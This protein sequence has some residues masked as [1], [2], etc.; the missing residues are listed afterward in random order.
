MNYTLPKRFE[1]TTR[2]CYLNEEEG[3]VGPFSAQEIVDLLDA[4]TI[5]PKTMVVEMGTGAMCRVLQ[6]RPFSDY[7]HHLVERKRADRRA[8][9]AFRQ[10]YRLVERYGLE[11]AVFLL[12]GMAFL[13]VIAAIALV[14]LSQSTETPTPLAKKGDKVHPTPSALDHTDAVTGH[15]DASE[16][17]NVQ[18]RL[19]PSG[20]VL[21]PM[22]SLNV[23][24]GKPVGPTNELELVPPGLRFDV[25]IDRNCSS[26]HY[27]PTG[28]MGDDTEL[29]VSL[30]S[31][32]THED[33]G[34][35]VRIEYGAQ[36]RAGWAG[37]YWQN[38]A[39]NWGTEDG[40]LNLT[41]FN[42][43]V[44]KARGSKGGE[45]ISE[46]KVGGIGIGSEVPHPDTADVSTK[47]IWLSD[48]WQLYEVNLAGEDLSYISGGF[49]VVFSAALNPDGAVIFVD[50]VYFTRDESLKP[51]TRQVVVDFP[52]YVYNDVLD[53]ANR[54]TPSGFSGD[55]AG[56][57]FDLRHH[58]N[59]QS[60]DSCVK[61]TYVPTEVTE[62]NGV[63]LYWLNPPGNWGERPGCY[64][65]SGANYLTFW[66]RGKTGKERVE[67]FRFGGAK[68]K[69]GDLASHRRGP[70]Q[71]TKHWK[72]YEFD[73]GGKNLTCVVAALSFSIGALPN[74]DGAV[75][76]LDNIKFE[77]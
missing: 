43:L 74:P 17:V 68:G 2:W 34:T 56:A 76:Y 4:R 9:G 37:V 33:Q 50:E 53:K 48:S 29:S 70:F 66:A 13:V 10:W 18:N 44:F 23:L 49:G 67:Q 54:F 20:E 39:E 22:E 73:L 15:A 61:V 27:F 42:K 19:P 64:D 6:V 59:P 75:I 24:I 55:A 57:R 60:G 3:Q 52:F 45:I 5:S 77:K 32:V 65:L 21:R 12:L 71:L 72:K 62:D 63:D 14:A 25:Y 46:V 41:K 40:G 31:P 1:E 35:S 47:P 30:D 38:P 11:R 69:Y 28:L 51:A 16:Q 7:L 36:G 8:S 58:D 26:N